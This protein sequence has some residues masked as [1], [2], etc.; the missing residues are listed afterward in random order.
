MLSEN[1]RIEY[2]RVVQ[3]A[4]YPLPWDATDE[5][6]GKRVGSCLACCRV[7]REPEGV[8]GFDRSGQ[9][10]GWWHRRPCWA[11]EHSSP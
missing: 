8:V 11:I 6:Y 7:V 5:M 2:P 10:A 3:I 9:V 4:A 1:P